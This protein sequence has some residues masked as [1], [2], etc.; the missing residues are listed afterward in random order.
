M[1]KK[2]LILSNNSGGGHRQT[3]QILAQALL[4]QGW[5]PEIISIY[6]EIFPDYFQI[7]GIEGEEIY[8]KL[9]LAKETSHLVYRIFFISAYYLI[10][11]PN[12]EKFIKRLI[13]FWQ[14]KQPA[15]VISVIP[16][17]NQVIARSLIES[18]KQTPFTII[19]TDLF[20]FEARHFLAPAGTWFVSDDYTYIVVGTE[21]AYQQVLSSYIPDKARVF[22]LSGN[23]IDPCFFKKPEFDRRAERKRLGLDPNQPVG[24]FLYG[25]FAP[26]RLL[27]LA[28]RLNQ[29]ENTAQFIFICGQN[30]TLKRR[31]SSLHTRYKKVV[32]G[33]T[34][35]VPYFM[36]LSDFL[37]G[38]SGPG[39][40]ME[41]IAADLPLLIDTTHN[42]IMHELDNIKW[43]E[44]HGFG[45]PFSNPAQLLCRIQQ[46]T[47][48]EV[49]DLLKMNVSR[50]ENR[51]VLEIPKTIET[52]MAHFYGT[53]LNVSFPSVEMP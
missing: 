50:Y 33:Y 6:R 35:E 34:P 46:L 38:K 43:I 45:L 16:L 17:L 49:Y 13:D 37:I 19:Q 51:A 2:I 22:R 48:S 10:I 32:V 23:I 31:L 7:F 21:T 36:H 53:R 15:L 5:E 20:E 4:N 14:Q 28:K 29:L 40:I 3:A 1:A 12:R 30:E 44:Q 42:G 47:S 26:H 39:T 27:G 18:N 52:I 9:I 41:G 8:N 25:G 11:Q 24:L